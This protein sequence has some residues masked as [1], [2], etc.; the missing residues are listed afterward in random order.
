MNLVS[1]KQKVKPSG[2]KL[3]PGSYTVPPQPLKSQSHATYVEES[4]QQQFQNNLS[5]FLM[6]S[7]YLCKQ[8]CVA[9]M[10]A[11]SYRGF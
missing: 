11:R 6:L 9:S 5:F 4:L 7:T 8:I 1:R 2:A 10:S 3:I